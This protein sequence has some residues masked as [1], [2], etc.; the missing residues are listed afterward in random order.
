MQFRVG[1]FNIFNQAFATTAVTRSDLD[2]TLET[3][4]NR[5]VDGVP[6]GVGGLVSACD[7]TAGFSFTENTINNFGKIN[8]KRGR[9]II[10][11]ALKYLT[12]KP[13]LIRAAP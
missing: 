5:T 12:S 3:V 10:E 6:N 1:V 11:F 4:C 7:P 9:R 8:L 2:L 13:T